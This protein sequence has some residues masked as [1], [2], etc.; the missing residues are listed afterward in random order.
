[1]IRGKGIVVPIEEFECDR[2][3]C[4]VGGHYLRC[5]HLN[6]YSL[7][8]DKKGKAQWIGDGCN[9]HNGKVGKKLSAQE[10]LEIIRKRRRKGR[11]TIEKEK[12]LRHRLMIAT[13]YL[14]SY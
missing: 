12:A 5:N 4:A 7:K 6:S 1:M 2:N 9:H 11:E 14:I 8:I 13:R 10:A 3:A